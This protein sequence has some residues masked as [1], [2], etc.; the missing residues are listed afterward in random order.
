METATLDKPKKRRGDGR[1]YLR[2]QVWWVQYYN[3]GRPF[4]ESSFSTKRMVAERKLKR[5][6]AEI[7][8][9]EFIGSKAERT[10]YEELA[11]DLLNYC[12]TKKWKSLV[13][14][15]DGTIYVP[16]EPH[17]RRFFAGWRAA[18]ITTDKLR[19]FV[20]KRQ[21]EGASNGTINRSLAALRH[22][23]SLAVRAKRLRP[24]D[25]PIIEMLEE[26]NTRKGFLEYDQYVRL[27]NALPDYFKPVLAMGYHTAMRLGEIRSLRWEQVNLLDHEIQLEPGTTKNDEARVV[28]I[29]GE[30][31][32]VIKMQLARRNAECPN[33]LFVFFRQGRPIGN[34]R[35]TWASA[36]VAVGLGSWICKNKACGG[37]MRPCSEGDKRFRCEECGGHRKRYAGRIFHD[38]RR[39]GIR[40]LV[41]AG[42]PETV[43][44]AISGHKT[45]AIFDRYNIVSRRDLTEAAKKLDTYL[46]EKRHNIGTE[47]TIQADPAELTN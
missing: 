41:R 12:V 39:T 26:S 19:Q 29:S 1:I 14:Q 17:L 22:M 44:M 45:R 7:Q 24:A 42:V 21:E 46:A 31:L 20:M 4:R 40:N 27:R 47:P 28:P 37:A 35:K 18:A 9:G 6:L 43:A 34:F 38:L 32:E 13:R 23:F 16:G 33:C 2:G 8:V 3:R 10:T 5:R 15:K 11:A 36:C 25:T 30:L